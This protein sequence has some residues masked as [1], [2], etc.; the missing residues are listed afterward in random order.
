L[1]ANTARDV[2][3][4]QLSIPTAEARVMLPV[5]WQCYN[6]SDQVYAW[7]SGD[8]QFNQHGV[9]RISNTHNEVVVIG[10]NNLGYTE[11][12]RSEGND[13][14]YAYYTGCMCFCNNS[15]SAVDGSCVGVG[16]CH[17]DIP[18]GLT[19]NAMNFRAYNHVGRLHFS[20]C[21]YAFLVDRDNYTFKTK[22]L[23]M[24]RNRTMPVWLDW[25]I[26][27]NLTCAQ[28]MEKKQGYACVSSNSKCNDTTNGPG[29]VCNC[30]EGY[31]GNPYV[32]DGCEGKY[33]RPANFASCFQQVKSNETNLDEDAHA[34]SFLLRNPC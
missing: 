24:D 9:Y 18:P 17:V 2:P 1:L 25:A 6:T 23:K 10:C 33:A 21:D 30:A 11:G 3:L 28:A 19:D 27:D 20:P 29:Y 22:D 26:R 14:S 8:V 5:A 34:P 15:D 4:N 32:V 31:Q 13:Y 16:C 12:Q 7:S